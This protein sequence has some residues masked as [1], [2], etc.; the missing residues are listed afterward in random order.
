VPVGEE[1][2][3]QGTVHRAEIFLPKDSPH[4]PPYC[5]MVTPAFH[6]NIVRIGEMITRRSHKVK[7]PLNLRAAAWAELNVE[8]LPLEK[9]DLAASL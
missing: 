3:K 2:F 1:S 5:R 7:S 9:V 4:R 8:K 6:P